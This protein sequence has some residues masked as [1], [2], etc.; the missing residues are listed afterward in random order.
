MFHNVKWAMPRQVNRTKENTAGMNSVNVIPPRPVEGAPN[1]TVQKLK[2][3]VTIRFQ[4][5]NPTKVEVRDIIHNP[6]ANVSLSDNIKC[7]FFIFLVL[8]CFF[9]PFTFKTT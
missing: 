4:L 7:L 9:F 2:S 5:N 1:P 3:N 8:F 6:K